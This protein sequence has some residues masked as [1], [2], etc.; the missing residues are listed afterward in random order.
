MD[1]RTGGAS[2]RQPL[3]RVG[4]AVASNTPWTGRV[5]EVIAATPDQEGAL[6]VAWDG[7][8]ETTVPL[9]ACSP[10]GDGVMVQFA[11]E[12]GTETRPDA[13]VLNRNAVTVPIIEESVTAE[14]V[15]RDA[16][17]VMI[18]QRAEDVPQT[19]TEETE[20]EELVVEQV[21]VGRA[22][23]EGEVVAPRQEGDRYII[24]I[25]V[26]E[27]VVIKRRMLAHELHITKR[28]ATATQTVETTVRHIHTA[29]ESG[30]LADR[31][32]IAADVMQ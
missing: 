31:T 29:I 12:A 15:W 20:Y 16:G 13:R 17:S 4:M 9:S 10:A 6:R 21:N 7:D 23:A 18:R 28:T 14:A 11:A 19:F 8:G 27:A 30:A 3:P 22:L 32:H 2:P 26:E 24:P 25:V 5:A 1:E